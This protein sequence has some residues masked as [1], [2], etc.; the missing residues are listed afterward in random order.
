MI[1]KVIYFGVPERLSDALRQSIKK[2]RYINFYELSRKCDPGAS[3]I[4]LFL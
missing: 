2:L 4:F 3:M 1:Y